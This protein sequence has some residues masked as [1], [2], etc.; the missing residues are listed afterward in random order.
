MVA[1]NR[2]DGDARPARTRPRARPPA[3]GA[4]ASSGL[5][6]AGRGRRGRRS[7]QSSARCA[8]GAA[9]P[10]ECLRLRRRG[11]ALS[12]RQRYPQPRPHE[13]RFAAP[14]GGYTARMP[15]KSTPTEITELVETMKRAGAAL[16][17]AGVPVMLGGGL[18]AW[19]RGGPPT[20]HDVDFFLRPEDAE[21]AL[22]ALEAAGFRPEQPPEHWLLKAHDGDVLVDLIFQPAGGA[23]DGAHFE[24]ATQ[25]EVLGQ[26]MLVAS[27]D[28]VLV[29]EAARAD[30]AGAGLPGGAC[31]RP[32]APRADR[33]GLRPRAVRG[34]ALRP[35]VLHARRRSWDRRRAVGPHRFPKRCSS[36]SAE[37]CLAEADDLLLERVVP[38]AVARP[39]VPVVRAEL[40]AVA[41]VVDH[42]VVELGRVLDLVLR[43]V[44]EDLLFIVM[45]VADDA[46]R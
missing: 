6:R 15:S 25:M 34:L 16:R 19:A 18:A 4:R 28:D 37:L 22:E 30:G 3:R 12:R 23:V 17:D 10:H 35:G 7:P 36:A 46:G 20:D 26:S 45:N 43:S 39:S 44:D 27:V 40:A 29:D 33:L 1:E 13:L 24:R 11:S 32:R 41:L 5:L 21:R 2:D 14:C 8:L 42:R 9:R 38:V 31:A